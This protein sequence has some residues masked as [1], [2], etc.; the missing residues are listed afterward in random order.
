MQ[1]VEQLQTDDSMDLGI[2]G[3]NFEM[4]ETKKSV[5]QLKEDKVGMNTEIANIKTDIAGIKTDIIGIK[6]DNAHVKQK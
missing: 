1:F 3:L 2:V 6:A 4:A 5:N